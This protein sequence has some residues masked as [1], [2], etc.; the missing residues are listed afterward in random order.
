MSAKIIGSVISC[1]ML[2]FLV[3]VTVSFYLFVA[4]DER[5]SDICYDYAE[6]VSTKGEF[7]E[8][9]YRLFYEALSKYGDFTVDLVLE[10]RDENGYRDVFY[11]YDH[12]VGATLK[13]GDLVT[14][15][16]YCT[17][18]SLVERMVGRQVRCSA[19]KR[20]VIE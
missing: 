2:S 17:D 9:N 13:R 3:L 20:A 10:T 19:I 8:E 14:I 15:A 7:S 6:T 1:A 4:E 18:A 11:G 12:V 5:I 16:V